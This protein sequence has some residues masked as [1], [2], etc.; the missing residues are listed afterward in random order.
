MLSL[1]LVGVLFNILNFCF[2]FLFMTVNLRKVDYLKKLFIHEAAKKK[3][4]HSAARLAC[5]S[6]DKVFCFAPATYKSICFA[7]QSH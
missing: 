4:T 1:F 6:L 7:N 3:Y 5:Y 2:V